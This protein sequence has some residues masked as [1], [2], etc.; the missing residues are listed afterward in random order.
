LLE[1]SAEVVRIVEAPRVCN[2]GDGPVGEIRVEEVVAATLHP[3]LQNVI[4][5]GD[6]FRLES[7]VQVSL[8]ASRRAGE[9]CKRKFRITQVTRDIEL[10]S[11]SE[12][13]L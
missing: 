4:R 11:I 9:L 1:A 6:F 5:D 13:R 12:R 8:R 7:H 3:L 2:F 10:Q